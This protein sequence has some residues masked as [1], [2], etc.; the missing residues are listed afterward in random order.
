MTSSS[1]IM[2]GLVASARAT[3]SRLRSRAAS[4]CRPSARSC[5]KRSSLRRISSPCARAARSYRS[6][7]NMGRLDRD[8]VVD[9]ESGK[10]FDDLEGAHNASRA[11]LLGLTARRSARRHN[12]FRLRP[13]RDAGDQAEQRCLAGSVRADDREKSRRPRREATRCSTAVR[14]R[15]RLTTSTTSRSVSL[16]SRASKVRA[17]GRATARCRWA[18]RR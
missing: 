12:G 17:C 11:D 9:A 14:P 13:A 5:Q 6:A 4:G 8:I 15:K 3:S 1:R 2:R 18:W 7:R 16:G 10:R